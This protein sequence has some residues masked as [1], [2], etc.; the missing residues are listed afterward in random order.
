MADDEPAAPAVHSLKALQGEPFDAQAVARESSIVCRENGRLRAKLGEAEKQ[1]EAARANQQSRAA[2][3]ES[4][5]AAAAAADRKCEELMRENTLGSQSVD[6]L[7]ARLDALEAERA[8]LIETNEQHEREWSAAERR[9][10]EA[11]AA[12]QASAGQQRQ[13]DQA[14]G[15]SYK[16]EAG[17]LRQRVEELERS[18]G[19]MVPA[20]QLADAR[21]ATEAAR[22]A[23]RDA[24]SARE[25][26]IRDA[27]AAKTLAAE[28]AAREHEVHKARVEQLKAEVNEARQRLLGGARQSDA[29]ARESAALKEALARAEAE[30]AKQRRCAETSLAERRRDEKKLVE[31]R[32]ALA[33]SERRNESLRSELDALR[34]SG[35]AAE[36]ERSN[37]TAEMRRLHAE[38]AKAKQAASRAADTLGEQLRAALQVV[39]TTQAELAAKSM[40]ACELC[41]EV[42][43]LRAELA[44]KRSPPPPPPQPTGSRFGEFVQLKREVATMRVASDLLA[45]QHG[46][47]A[48]VAQAMATA[49]AAASSTHAPPGAPAGALGPALAPSPRTC[50]NVGV[51]PALGPAQHDATETSHAHARF[52]GARQIMGGQGAAVRMNATGQ[53]GA[54]VR[55]NPAR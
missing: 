6:A 51:G 16:A 19:S 29:A 18:L 30:L 48:E 20:S 8:R 24:S 21:A 1:L 52:G 36:G 10:E 3:L 12:A 13:R 26:A 23:A 40:Q 33:S 45:T 42:D 9:A 46:L 31:V 25:A 38:A 49:S 44:R 27:H 2:Q 55:M 7:Q 32:Q 37:L 15:A 34:A 50:R 17:A 43:R 53:Q 47:G 14:Q 22:E 5:R 35:G 28:Q 41:D 11:I 54:A 39:E 4:A